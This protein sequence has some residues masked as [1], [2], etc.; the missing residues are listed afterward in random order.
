MRDNHSKSV[1]L[2]MSEFLLWQMQIAVAKY[3]KMYKIRN[4]IKNLFSL[5]MWKN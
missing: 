4:I 1:T 5:K 2:D 3:G